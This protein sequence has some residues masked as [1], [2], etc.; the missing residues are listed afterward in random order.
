MSRRV[1]SLSALALIIAQHVFALPRPATVDL[2][3]DSGLVERADVLD[4]QLAASRRLEQ[5]RAIDA[6]KAWQSYDHPLPHCKIDGSCDVPG[7]RSTVDDLHIDARK[8]SPLA[9]YEA[10][11]ANAIKR[12]ETLNERELAKEQTERNQRRL[13]YCNTPAAC[14]VHDSHS[15]GEDEKGHQVF[16]RSDHTERETTAQRDAATSPAAT[17]FEP[18]TESL[19]GFPGHGWR[20]T[21]SQ[22]ERVIHGIPPIGWRRSLQHED[23][24]RTHSPATLES[25]AESLRGFPGHGWGAASQSDRT[26]PDKWPPMGWR[27]SLERDEDFAKRQEAKLGSARSSLP[28]APDANSLRGFPGHGWRETDSQSERVIHGSPPI[29]WRR[30]L[31]HDEDFA[32]RQDDGIESTDFSATFEF[33]TESLRGSPG[34]GWRKTDSQSDR[35][36]PSKGWR[37]SVESGEGLMNRQVG[38][39]GWTR[40]DKRDN[41]ILADLKARSLDNAQADTLA[42][43][44]KR[45]QVQSEHAASTRRAASS[46]SAAGLKRD[47]TAI[48][49]DL[50]EASLAERIRRERADIQ[51]QSREQTATLYR[52]LKRNEAWT[53][54]AERSNDAVIQYLIKRELDSKT[55]HERYLA[56]SDILERAQASSLSSETLDL[57]KREVDFQKMRKRNIDYSSTSHPDERDFIED[58]ENDEQ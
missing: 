39:Y 15:A 40:P 51:M 41:A 58:E 29:G 30:S 4:T 36:I 17:A 54:S 24:G 28:V 27:R 23:H 1:L 12:S 11:E 2:A 3:A 8:D 38:G 47:L 9:P 52:L 20:E 22:S 37:R 53:D 44:S 16:A 55:L 46:T 48:H 18:G 56:L 42:A 10:V 35:T 43:M 33:G 26:I 25:G 19:R 31:Q 32:K 21:D 14:T 6:L 5:R 34:H 45:Q 49:G 13:V 57:L 50:S 7:T